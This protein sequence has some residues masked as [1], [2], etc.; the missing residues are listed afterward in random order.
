MTLLNDGQK[1][2][3]AELDRGAFACVLGCGD[4]PQPGRTM[5]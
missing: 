4:A 2:K 1:L 3:T 5:P